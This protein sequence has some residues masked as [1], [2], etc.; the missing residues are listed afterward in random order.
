M[1]FWLRAINFLALKASALLTIA[2]NFIN[3]RTHKAYIHYHYS[4]GI[5]DVPLNAS[6]EDWAKSLGIE[7][8]LA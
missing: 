4:I 5:S 7:I 8:Y 3:R 6:V 1:S 2:G